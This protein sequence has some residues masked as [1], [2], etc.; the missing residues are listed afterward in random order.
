M[1]FNKMLT[2]QTKT[3]LEREYDMA[4]INGKK[5]AIIEVKY[6]AKTYAQAIE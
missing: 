1:K 2:K 3:E 5:I 6:N 4:L